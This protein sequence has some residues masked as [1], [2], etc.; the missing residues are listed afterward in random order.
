MVQPLCGPHSCLLL[1]VCDLPSCLRK[2]EVQRRI[3]LLCELCRT[4][5]GLLVTYV[6]TLQSDSRDD[7][8]LVLELGIEVLTV[9]Y[10]VSLLCG[11]I[12]VQTAPAED[13]S[14]PCLLCRFSDDIL[15]V[16][17]VHECGGSAAHH[18]HASNLGTDVEV[19]IGPVGIDL[20][21]LVQEIGE[22]KIVD[23]TLHYG[24]RDMCMGVDHTRHD[25]VAC[26]IDLPVGCAVVRRTDGYDLLTIDDDVTTD[27]AP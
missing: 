26:G 13:S 14:D 5:A 23:D 27:D 15:R 7:L 3:D 20:E 4:D 22:C 12:L 1:V 8:P 16:I 9:L 25:D 24:H 17:Q 18:L 10:R 2:V 21:H 6:N 19:V 11:L